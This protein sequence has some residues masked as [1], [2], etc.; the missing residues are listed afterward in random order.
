M[1]IKNMKLMLLGLI[2]LMG[3]SNASA[4]VT[5]KGDVQIVD[6]VKYEVKAD[7]DVKQDENG[8]SV[9]N[10]VYNL[11]TI[12]W[13]ALGGTKSF[14]T[15]EAYVI[16]VRGT[17]SDAE[18]AILAI[19]AEVAGDKGTYEVVEI[20]HAWGKA[21]GMKDAY[22]ATTALSI[23][24]TNLKA[25]L[26]V[27]AY[28]DFSKLTSL[29]ITDASTS[30]TPL[31]ASFDGSACAFKTTL[32]T[33]NLAGSRISAIADNGLKG[34]TALTGFDFT[35]IT[36]IG[37]S[38]FE[39]DYGISTL[40]IPAS[41]EKIGA[42]AFKNMYKAKSGD[43]PAK[44][45]TTLTING[46]DITKDSDGKITASVIP[47]AF[48]GNQLLA[49]VT[50]G[51]TTATVINS[52]AFANAPIT[53][54][55]LSAATALATIAGAFPTGLA[56]QSVKLYGSDLTTLKSS[57]LDLSGSQLSLTVITLPAKL[58]KLEQKFNDFL[59]LEEL[60]LSVTK[61]TKI[62]DALFE[63]SKKVEFGIRHKI[64]PT[65]QY[66]NGSNYAYNDKGL[67]EPVWIDPALKTVKLNAE[68]TTIG[69]TYGYSFN[70]CINLA[71][72]TGLNQDKL[73][74][75]LKRSFDGTAMTAV[76]LS[77]ATNE[78]FTTIPDRAFGNMA[79]LATVTLPAQI[80]SIEPRAFAN[81]E[82]LTSIN[83][84]DLSGLTVLNPMFHDG[85]VS[86]SW[87]SYYDGTYTI[88]G[89][90]NEV[91]IPI[92]SLTLPSGLKTINPGALQLLDITEITIP[93]TVTRID[94][95]ALQGCVKLETF[96][97][98]DAKSRTIYDTAFRGD[99]HL[100]KVRMVTKTP[101]SSITIDKS[102]YFIDD[103]SIDRIFK[104][105]KKDVLTFVVNAED[106][107]SLLAAGWTV[108]NL[109]YCTLTS[110]EASVYTFK[111][112]SKVGEF[113][114]SN[115]YNSD[116]ATWF[117]AENFE[118]FG[119]IVQGSD[120]VLVPATVEEGYYKVEIKE[121]CIIRSKVQKAEYELKNASFNNIST[122]PTDNDLTYGFKKAS[123]LKYQYKL[124]IK[125]G[126]VAFYRI[127]TGNVSGVFIEAETP[128]DRLN[129]VFDGEATGIQSIA[130]EAE[131]NA[132]IYNLNG[133][134]VNK[135]GKGI[136][137]QN[138]KK[139]VK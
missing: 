17:A 122:M 31:T 34:Y 41:V 63:I 92:T 53:S 65:A 58:A 25:A 105:N 131:S 72:V 3:A 112:A 125:N 60:D 108:T 43:T 57:D 61:V 83:L 10:V 84:Q 111:E 16:G 76:D 51:S 37:A 87:T 73:E 119:A 126:V 1:K 12:K 138:G 91:A 132:P 26:S 101:G 21:T 32:A 82:A 130:T 106:E 38:A 98:N 99:D 20:D 134:R 62:P 127:S 80:T 120:V 104:G 19:P 54:I 71:T 69:E 64:D 118:V 107:A 33:L 97:W 78:K 75:I 79:N 44:G 95:Y 121:P 46:A 124:G 7:A 74:A 45:L 100:K 103:Q 4:A 96:E 39:G 48:T 137:I 22:A 52:G 123:R 85:V 133:V 9:S 35:G 116:Q 129:I 49:S 86:S 117:P 102:T 36:Q 128:K 77:A 40:T 27:D 28:K 109:H 68:T 8:R 14:E 89:T 13:T 67:T 6:G 2:G 90:S 29:T 70:G 18:V 24:I 66:K 50:V 136:Y 5:T 11:Y 23:D 114:Y 30:Q 56:L 15:K 81:A 55:D 113:F 135:A 59:Y 139:F 47:A 115:Y 88:L 93:A 110:K 42:D 94:E